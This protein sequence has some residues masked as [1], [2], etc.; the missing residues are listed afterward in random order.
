MSAESTWDV[1]TGV[2]SCLTGDV[3]LTALLS[4]G[5]DSILDHVPA[6][7]SFPYVVIGEARAKPMNTQAVSGNDI[8]L[9]I[10][11]YSRGSGMQQVRKI[12]AAI[13]DALHH[14]SFSVQNQ[15]L[16]LC[17]C[18]E[19]ETRLEEDGITRHGIQHFQIITEPV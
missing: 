5:A 19:S 2:F 12:M 7:T 16:V 13:Y 14:A 18:L 1:Q 17:Q 10:H 3:P 8:T 11:A 6:G 9:T 4:S 15:V